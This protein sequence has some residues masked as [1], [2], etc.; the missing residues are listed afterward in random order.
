[1]KNQLFAEIALEQ[2]IKAA[3]VASFVLC[4]F[5]HGVVDSVEAFSLCAL[6]DFHLASGSAALSFCTLLKVG[7]GVPYAFADEFSETACMVSFLK[8][9]ALESLSD[10]GIAFAIGLASHCEVH[11][12]FGAFAFEVSLQAHHDVFGATLSYADH[13]LCYIY[14]FSV[15]SYFFKLACWSLALGAE[16]GSGITF[17]NISANFTYELT[18]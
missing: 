8:S 4:H 3:T 16:F 18:H 12:H 15:L 6:S 1:M 11:A 10:F 14:F 9:I 7:L 13:V 17:V 5:M 2:A